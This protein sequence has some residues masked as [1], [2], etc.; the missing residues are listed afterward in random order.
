MRRHLFIHRDVLLARMIGSEAEMTAQI[1]RGYWKA[2][3]AGYQH[4]TVDAW[5]NRSPKIKSVTY[6]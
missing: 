4:G 5:Q 1:G 3:H 2:M 6:P